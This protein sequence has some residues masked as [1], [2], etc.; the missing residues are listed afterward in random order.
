MIVGS[1]GG[2][3]FHTVQLI[4]RAERDTTSEMNAIA[5]EAQSLMEI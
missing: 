5:M 2:G 1:A 3:F 4:I